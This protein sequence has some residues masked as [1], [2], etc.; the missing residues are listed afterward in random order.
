MEFKKNLIIV[1]GLF[2]SLLLYTCTTDPIIPNGGIPDPNQNIPPN[3]GDTDPCPTGTISFQYEILP[4]M[5]SNCA[6]S[7]CHDA[8]TAE[9]DIVLDSYDNIMKEVTPND[10]NDS[11]LYESMIETD[12]D[13][14]MP[15]PGYATMTTEQIALV[16]DWINQGAPN[17]MCG[18]P[19]DSTQSSFSIDIFPLVQNIC[20]GC[21]NSGFTLGNVNL[22]NHTEIIPYITSGSFLGSIEHDVNYSNMPP[23]GGKMSD[24]NIAQIQKWIDEGALDN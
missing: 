14:I 24:C 17:T 20:V 3:P 4:M 15:P 6:F 21:H 23:S 2:T 8:T 7:G 22:E 12:P 5:L 9:D 10:I 13:D 11:E 1:L 19:C 16:R 18:T